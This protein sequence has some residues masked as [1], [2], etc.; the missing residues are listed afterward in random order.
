MRMIG[1]GQRSIYVI[2]NRPWRWPEISNQNPITQDDIKAV[3]T[4]KEK[5]ASTRKKGEKIITI[6]R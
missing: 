5:N 3:P 1:R 2:V 4:T 6:F